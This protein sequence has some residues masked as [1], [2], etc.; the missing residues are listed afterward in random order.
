MSEET[1]EVFVKN[2]VARGVDPDLAVVVW[3]ANNKMDKATMDKIKSQGHE[4]GSRISFPMD[5]GVNCTAEIRSFSTEGVLVKIL[6][7]KGFMMVP[8][9]N[10]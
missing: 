1:L 3:C 6:P 4:V 9:K 7:D 2:Q 5:G 10:F 8:A